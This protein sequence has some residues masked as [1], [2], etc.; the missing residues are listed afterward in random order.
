MSLIFEC[1]PWTETVASRLSSYATS[2]QEG[3]LFLTFVVAWLQKT[4]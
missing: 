3:T 2:T 4:R 1:S